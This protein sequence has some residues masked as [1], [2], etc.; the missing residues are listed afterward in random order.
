MKRP[1]P[2]ATFLLA[3]AA[4]AVAFGVTPASKTNAAA[5]RAAKQSEEIAR[6]ID[7]LLSARLKPEPLPRVLPNPFVVVSGVV[8]AQRSDGS[9]AEAPA[10]ESPVDAA[11]DTATAAQPEEFPAFTSAELLARCAA[12]LKFGGMI[13]LNDRMQV[14]I[15]NVPRKEGDIVSVTLG[16]NKVYLRVARISPGSVTMRLN[17]AEQ[18]INY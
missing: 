7:S 18:V 10:G 2:L 4:G 3:A 17:E 14:V 8:S 15:N 1:L 11:N 13:Q 6:R 16:P 9:T 5:Q 12:T